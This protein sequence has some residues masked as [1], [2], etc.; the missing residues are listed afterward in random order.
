MLGATHEEMTAAVARALGVSDAPAQ[1]AASPDAVADVVLGRLGA[2]VLGH[3]AAGLLHFCAPTASGHVRGYSWR[4][5]ASVPTA[6]RHL[7]LPLGDVEHRG[8]GWTKLGV[9]DEALAA[10]PL[11]GLLASL[12]GRAPIDADAMTF[13]SSAALAA[14]LERLPAGPVRTG[15]LCH[16]VQDIAVPHHARGWLLRG[17]QEYEAAMHVAWCRR[18]HGPRPTRR[19][20]SGQSI[21]R[22][23]EAAVEWPSPRNV[24]DALDRAIDLTAVALLA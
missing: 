14:W 15:C 13:P 2:C 21:R 22:V 8:D 16:L 6:L 10:H 12:V 17:H 7:D 9:S 4:M 19:P 18:R 23:I 3:S 24:D 5:D 20:P 11:R 1:Y